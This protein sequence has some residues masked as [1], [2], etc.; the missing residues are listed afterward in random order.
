M[1]R[2]PRAAAPRRS[3]R[4]RIS[5]SP[6]ASSAATVST[7][8]S[9]ATS[10]PASEVV[11]ASSSA[12]ADQGNAASVQA[13]VRAEVQSALTAA[14][15]DT[16]LPMLSQPSTASSG[17]LGQS[18][19]ASANQVA[20][21]AP[22]SANQVSVPSLPAPVA[23]TTCAVPS[24]VQERILRGE[25]IE[26][27]SLLPE[28]LA[29]GNDS[30]DGSK[31]FQLVSSSGPAGQALSIV[32]SDVRQVKRKVLD[33]TTWLEA[34]TTYTQVVTA[35][36]PQRI[37]EFLAYQRI[38]LTANRQ[39]YSQAW[40]EYDRQLR[41]LVAQQPSRRLDV[42]DSNLWQ[43]AFTGHARPACASCKSVHPGTGNCPFRPSSSTAGQPR[44]TESLLTRTGNNKEIC[45]NYNGGR[46]T[47]TQCVYAHVCNQCGKAGHPRVKCSR[48]RTTGGPA[49][50]Q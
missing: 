50:R 32:E 6:Y 15:T 21:P 16:I 26:L 45:R 48:R 39:F 25:F 14:I 7:A 5:T 24:S 43:L 31:T 41:L 8:S 40:L 9:A 29:Y 36:A 4:G 2:A 22:P 3:G 44:S 13:M 33:I 17:G 34:W 18:A 30:N 46:C 27:S 10:E 35:A 28:L 1:P 47:A 23:P 49:A 37:Q 11:D 12:P 20:T 42:I 38:I 19:P